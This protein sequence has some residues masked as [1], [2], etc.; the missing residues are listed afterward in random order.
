[1]GSTYPNLAYVPGNLSSFN[2]NGISW[3]HYDFRH[4]CSPSNCWGIY[5]TWT[6][7]DFSA[8]WP[9]LMNAVSSAMAGSIGP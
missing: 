8:V 1:M 9:A 4:D 3:T 7:A 2:Q 6:S 5:H